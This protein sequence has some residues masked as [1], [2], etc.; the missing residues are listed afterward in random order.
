MINVN[1][2]EKVC[3]KCGAKKKVREFKKSG[4]CKDGT[5]NICVVC[6]SARN[7]IYD[8]KKKQDLF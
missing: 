2:L 1:N 4:K 3:I 7:R 5:E 6:H 8:R